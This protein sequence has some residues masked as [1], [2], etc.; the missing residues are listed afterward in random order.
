[1]ENSISFILPAYNAASTLEESIHSIFN[2]NFEEGDEVIIINDA[3]TDQ[4]QAKID[5]LKS[6]YPEIISLRHN[7]NKGSAA[8][9]RNTGIDSSSNSLIFCLD[10]DNLL[11]PGSIKPLK[12]Y[13]L[14]NSLEVA[15]FGEIKYFVDSP[16]N[17]T[18]SWILD[19]KFSFVDA[20]NYPAKNPASSGNY[21]FTKESWQKAGRYKEALGGALDSFAFG[22]A[23]LATG[24]SFQCLP[25]SFY[26]HRVGYESTYIKEIKKSNRSLIVLRAILPYIDQIHPSDVDY[27]MCQRYRYSWFDR[28]NKRKLR[29]NPYSQ[30]EGVT[31]REAPI[32]SIIKKYLLHTE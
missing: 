27:I 28:L 32:K 26:L 25:N 30:T 1:M 20:I 8:A 23:Q 12:Q 11:V 3:S 22:L 17:V 10:S 6:T 29:S 7:I 31:P 24:S 21:L 5:S 15:G 9:S 13:L 16:E 4:T 19:E 14:E 18:H 2:N